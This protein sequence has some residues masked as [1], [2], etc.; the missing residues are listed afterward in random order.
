MKF[1]ITVYMQNDFVTGSLA[2]KDAQKI[3]G[4]L[5]EYLKKSGSRRIQTY[6]HAGYTF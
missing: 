3:V 6:L 5:A 2:N 4:P 1:V